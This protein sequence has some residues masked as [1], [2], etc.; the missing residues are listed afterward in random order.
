MENV[1]N[2]LVT[3]T[4]WFEWHATLFMWSAKMMLPQEK[5]SQYSQPI[6][7]R[8]RPEWS[9][10]SVL[11]VNQVTIYKGESSFNLFGFPNA[12]KRDF[13]L[14]D[15]ELSID[16]LLIVLDATEIQGSDSV[17]DT[18]KSFIYD[19]LCVKSSWGRD[20]VE[21]Y[22]GTKLV[23]ITTAREEFVKIGN[24]E[25]CL[26]NNQ[27]VNFLGQTVDLEKWGDLAGSFPEAAI[28][29]TLERIGKILDTS[30]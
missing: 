27:R 1:I 17:D 13:S 23:L 16:V 30:K 20:L 7:W 4:T 6:N 24:H 21:Q 25:I 22:D 15:L 26:P 19:E 3:G 12:I 29:N 9:S 5:H 11:Y 28:S 8:N 14:S 18:I 2:V 10:N